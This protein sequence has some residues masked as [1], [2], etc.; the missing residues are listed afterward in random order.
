MIPTDIQNYIEKL[1][2]P[3]PTYLNELER[4]T[5]QKTVLP[6]MIS[7]Y[8]QG[9]LLSMF[10]K[11]TRPRQILE[12]GTFTGFSTLCL[13]EGLL[14]EGQ[15]HTI[16]INDEFTVLQNKYFEKSP[17]RNQIKQYVGN[18]REIIPRLSQQFDLIFLDAD[19]R[20]YPEYFKLLVAQ[21]NRGG[22]LL[23]DNVLWYGKVAHKHI[24]DAETQALRKYNELLLA[25]KSFEVIILPVRDGISVARKII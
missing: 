17:Y 9:R 13:A 7:G 12:I 11:L 21:L 5:Y 24:I 10:S 3:Q 20:F 8:Y 23:A 15:I 19:K 1:A 6:Q 4:E 16:D 22:L 18:A 25:D 14:P 2:S